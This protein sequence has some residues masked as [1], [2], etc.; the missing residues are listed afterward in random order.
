MTEKS[1]EEY[2]GKKEYGIMHQTTFMKVNGD[3]LN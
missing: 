2:V 1:F 3:I